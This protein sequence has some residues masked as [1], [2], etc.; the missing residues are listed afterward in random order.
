MNAS[1]TGYLQKTY[2]R[3]YSIEE[4]TLVLLF[5]SILHPTDEC[6][7]FG[8]HI[9][10]SAEDRNLG[11]HPLL[12]YLSIVKPDSELPLY[13]NHLTRLIE[14][15]SRAHLFPIGHYVLPDNTKPSSICSSYRI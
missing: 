2:V 13:L 15:D 4:L 14:S 11:G 3:E 5:L 7:T 8:T 9:S 6:T 1:A 10:G 12:H